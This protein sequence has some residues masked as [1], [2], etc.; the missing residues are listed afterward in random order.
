MAVAVQRLI[1]YTGGM[2]TVIFMTNPASDRFIGIADTQMTSGGKASE[3]AETD[4]KI[5]SPVGVPNIVI[6]FSGHVSVKTALKSLRLPK[7]ASKMKI[8]NPEEA[9]AFVEVVLVP[10]IRDHLNRSFP[11]GSE[12]VYGPNFGILVWIKGTDCVYEVGPDLSVTQNKSGFYSVGSGSHYAE[13]SFDMRPQA[14]PIDHMTYAVKNDIYSS[15]P[16]HVVQ[17]EK[18]SNK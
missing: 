15:G 1:V 12:F 17:I 18:G 4:S 7:K 16:F 10:A 5:F 11:P 8:T 3:L 2:T 6:G 14:D 9:S 13:V